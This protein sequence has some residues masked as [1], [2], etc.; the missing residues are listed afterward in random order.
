MLNFKLGP[1]GSFFL[2]V[3]NFSMWIVFLLL[4]LEGVLN[5]RGFVLHYKW[6]NTSNV[7]S[8]LYCTDLRGT[9]PQVS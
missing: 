2:I 9:K 1:K 6:H 7:L 5:F 8:Y 4:D 3:L